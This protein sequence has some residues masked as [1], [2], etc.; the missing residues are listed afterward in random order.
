M[1]HFLG[2]PW[3]GV[4]YTAIFSLSFWMMSM[5][6]E[7]EGT[8]KDCG[9]PDSVIDGTDGRC[10]NCNDAFLDDVQEEAYGGPWADCDVLGSSEW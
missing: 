10:E 1:D 5:K 7:N 2:I 6:E 3:V 4:S 8:C 9:Q